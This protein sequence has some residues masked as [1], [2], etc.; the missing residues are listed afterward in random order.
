MSLARHEPEDLP[1]A[2]QR[3]VRQRHTRP[4][5]V[6][7]GDR[8]VAIQRREDGIAGHER[9]G[10]SIGA[11]P[12]VHEIELIGKRICIHRGSS[13]EILGPDG[14]GTDVDGSA[15]RQAALE[16]H[17]VAIS[18]SIGRD[19]LV[20]L[21]DRDLLPRHAPVEAREHRPRRSAARD[22]KRESIAGGDRD[23]RRCS[24]DLSAAFGHRVHVRQYLDLERHQPAFSSWPPNCLRMAESRRFSKSSNPRDENRE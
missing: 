15:G 10:V 5:L 9:G 1:R 20:D 13:L 3:G 8:D 21:E 6:D 24:D 2:I 12:E 23:C 16:L 17:E 19:A 18:V 14:H 4:P 22:R 11:E 7:A